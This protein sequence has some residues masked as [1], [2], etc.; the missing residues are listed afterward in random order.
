MLSIKKKSL[1]P[2]YSKVLLTVKSYKNIL[3]NT[4][5]AYLGLFISEK[6]LRKK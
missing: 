2:I 3:Y 4:I 1:R 6:Y 5:L